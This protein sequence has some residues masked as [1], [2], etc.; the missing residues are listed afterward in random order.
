[1]IAPLIQRQLIF[2][3]PAVMLLAIV[4]ILF[5]FGGIAV[6]FAGPL[7]V[8]VFIAIEKLYVRDSLGEATALPGEPQRRG[9][10]MAD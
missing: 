6:I 2:I 5:V 4:I 10:R 3:P 7:A 8:I 9:Q 1:M